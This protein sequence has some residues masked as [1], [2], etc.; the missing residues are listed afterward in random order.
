MRPE[1]TIPPDYAVVVDSVAQT[2]NT[3]PAPIS[4]TVSGVMTIHKFPAFA[5]APKPIGIIAITP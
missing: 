3:G 1:S 2:S 5:I 4:A